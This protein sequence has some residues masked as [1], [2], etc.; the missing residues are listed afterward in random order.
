M[1]HI[2]R[3]HLFIFEKKAILIMSLFGLIAIY[4]CLLYTL[5]FLIKIYAPVKFIRKKPP[6]FLMYYYHIICFIKILKICIIYKC[7]CFYF[8]KKRLLKRRFFVLK[9]IKATTIM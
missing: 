3:K 1:P 7:K 5:S 2:S 4:K 8:T 9:K 6:Y